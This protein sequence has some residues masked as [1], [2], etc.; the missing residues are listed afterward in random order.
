[1]PPG[2]KTQ[3]RLGASW[4]TVRDDGGLTSGD[5][6]IGYLYHPGT[7]I[8]RETSQAIAGGGTPRIETRAVDLAARTTGVVTTVPD[9]GGRRIAASAGY[10]LDER[11]LREK[12]TREDGTSWNYGYN[13]RREVT[14]GVKKLANGSLAAGLQ[15]GYQFDGIGNRQWAKSGGDS[16]GQNPRTT[17]Y[18]PNALNQ[19][20][21]ITTPGSF[22]VLVRSPDAVG[23]AVNGSNS[24]VTTQGDFHHA[25]ATATNT[26]GAWVDL[27]IT[28]P[29][30]VPPHATGHCWLP[31][32]SFT[33][34]HDE[35]GNLLDDGRWTNTWDAENR[36]ITQTTTA[37]A[38]AA[39]VP[40]RKIE[41]TYDWQSRRIRKKVSSSTDGSTWTLVSDE[42]FL[43]NGW[44]PVAIFNHHPS[45][46]NLHPST[47]IPQPSSLPPLG[48]RP[49]RH[50]PG[51]GR[52]RRSSSDH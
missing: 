43:Y 22:D 46:L 10:M 42:R 32:A 48:P 9:G 6:Q 52:R 35:D 21:E 44:N 5:H 1:M 28:S 11:G 23:V 40:R 41:N 26:N 33:P 3:N 19:Y 14:S 18:Q 30:G 8:L 20:S 24:S 51:C 4:E 34:I 29:P 38:A 13:D 49:Q 2:L 17:T 12:L 37:L 39:G 50:P 25:E 7:G 47:F 31:P 36:L 16:S 15:F 45:S 27:N